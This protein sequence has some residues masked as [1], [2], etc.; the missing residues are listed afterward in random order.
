MVR[1]AVDLFCG[2]GGLSLG[3][4]AAGFDVVAG[5]DSWKPAMDVYRRN[6]PG[7]LGIL[8]DLSDEEATV[9]IVDRFRPFMIAGG[10]PC[11]DFS[12]AGSRQEGARA[13][14]TVKFAN[15]VTK[16]GPMAFV[17]ENVPNARLSDAFQMAVE[18]FRDA[19]YGLSLKVLDASFCGVPQARKRMFLI[20]MLGETDG[21]LDEAIEARVSASPMT[22]RQYDPDLVG[23][24]HYYRHP[25]TYKK[26]AVFSIDEPS[27]TIRGINRPK[28]K[29]YV[30]HESDSF[31]PNDDRV[32]ALTMEQ[33]ALI[34]TFPAGYFPPDVP[35]A[36]I[37]QMIGNAVPVKLG[38][39]VAE[40]LRDHLASVLTD[41]FDHFAAAEISAVAR[42]AA[43]RAK[44]RGAGYPGFA[45]E[46]FRII[47]KMHLP[48]QFIEAKELSF[49]A[50]ARLKRR[51]SKAK[52][53]IEVTQDA[54]S[55]AA[56]LDEEEDGFLQAAE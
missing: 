23:F 9:R 18:V 26:R 20:G 3:L 34:Q 45:L 38:R 15:V 42:K 17:M 36:S 39:F 40:C 41:E 1:T 50:E 13:D 5:L 32:Q 31:D 16:V 14:L 37:E 44:E 47:T 51:K 48:E 24:D 10:P 30:P 28:P 52:K 35:K 43:S 19:G 29:T 7:H 4:E 49:A 11:Q 2:C 6:H 56:D 33:R 25:R 53:D 22:I 55:A 46:I 54:S 8:H 27:P 12:S 21:F